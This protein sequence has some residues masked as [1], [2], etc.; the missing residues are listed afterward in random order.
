[1]LA[2]VESPR[3]TAGRSS[4]ESVSAMPGGFKSR[5]SKVGKS[6]ANADTEEVPKGDEEEFKP[7][8]H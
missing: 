1:M 6:N 8:M 2:S 3:L 5:K 7:K 4:H